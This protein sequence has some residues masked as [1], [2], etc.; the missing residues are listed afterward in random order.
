[1][2]EISLEQLMECRRI[3]E[4]APLPTGFIRVWTPERGL[5]MVYNGEFK[6]TGRRK[7]WEKA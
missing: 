4:S 5:R 7:I 6:Q 3:L 1:M 2:S